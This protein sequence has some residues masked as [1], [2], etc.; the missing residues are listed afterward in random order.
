ML[1]DLLK[2]ASPQTNEIVKARHSSPMFKDMGEKSLL[3]SASLI[4]ADLGLITGLKM[5][6]GTSAS[7]LVQIASESLKNDYPFYTVQLIQKGVKEKAHV[8]TTGPEKKYG[9]QLSIADL[10]QVM[11]AFSQDVQEADKEVDAYM[12]KNIEQKNL[13]EEQK[14]NIIRKGIQETFESG[15]FSRCTYIDFNQ[16]V[17]DGILKEGYLHDCAYAA[18]ESLH[19]KYAM[20]RDTVPAGSTPESL[21]GKKEDRKSTRLNSSHSSVSRM[22]S[23]A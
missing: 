2:V 23:S 5:P 7:R 18:F 15:D 6:E 8:L 3:A 19:K 22:P 16:M 10:H 11:N 14:Q 21:R 12:Q 13:S 1:K 4:L 17:R 20:L 9:G